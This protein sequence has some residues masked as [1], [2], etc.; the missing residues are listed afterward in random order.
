MRDI[1][2]G[3]DNQLDMF[4][5]LWAKAGD[6]DGYIICPFTEEILN[7][8]KRGNSWFSCFAHL[9]PKGRFTYFKL[10]PDNIRVVYPEFHRI[11]DQGTEKDRQRHPDWRFDLWDQE[12]EKMKIQYEKFKKE[13]L[14]P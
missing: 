14:L 5:D 13:N 1:N 10:N 3:F 2:F 4:Y 8:Y 9:L 11:V 12:V 6:K 7:G